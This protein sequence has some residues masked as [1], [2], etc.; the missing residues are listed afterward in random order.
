MRV[1]NILV[2]RR[3]KTQ[4]GFETKNTV[5]LPAS[6]AGTQNNINNN[7]DNININNNNNNVRNDVIYEIM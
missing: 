2:K 4:F 1:L 7:T 5:L 3:K 6:D